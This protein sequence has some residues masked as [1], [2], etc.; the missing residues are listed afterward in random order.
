MSI[1]KSALA[2]IHVTCVNQSVK[3]FSRSI[4]LIYDRKLANNNITVNQFTILSYVFYYESIS[5]GKLANR[6]AM[7]RTTLTKNLKPLF[8]DRYIEI[9]SAQD[10]RVKQISLTTLGEEVLEKS[11]ALWKE[12]QNEIYRKYG[13]QKVRQ[14][15]STLNG[16]WIADTDQTS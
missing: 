8:R 6:L 13:K 2:A 14:I 15:V 11:V 10:K 7:D 3:K 1:R 9:I 16:L 12:A 5:L 4:G